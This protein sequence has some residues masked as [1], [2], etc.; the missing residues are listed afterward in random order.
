[1]RK[2][3]GMKIEVLPEGTQDDAKRLPG[4]DLFLFRHGYTRYNQEK[5]YQGK[6]DLPLTAEE[7]E[8]ITPYQFE[9]V[10]GTGN[11]LVPEKRSVHAREA[12]CSPET[13]KVPETVYVSPALRARQTADL[14]FPGM[15]QAVVPGFREMDFGV[16]EGRSAEEMAED[17]QYR[18]WVD[19]LCEDPVPGGESLQEFIS[20]VAQ[21]FESLAA[22]VMEEGRDRLLIVAHGG[23]QMAVMSRFGRTKRPYWSWQSAPGDALR[24]RVICSAGQEI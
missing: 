16:F 22:R 3:Q 14:L 18:S 17:P 2:I 23:T 6:M 9:S 4:V 19:S 21:Q 12:G 13:G 11:T 7:M 5:R 1:M 20:R 15:P 10:S 8:R 24:A